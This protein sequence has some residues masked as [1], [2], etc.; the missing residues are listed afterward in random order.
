MCGYASGYA[1]LELSSLSVSR[2]GEGEGGASDLDSLWA[3]ARSLP[4]DLPPD[5]AE[6]ARTACLC[7][8]SRQFEVGLEALLAGL[9]PDCNTR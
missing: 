9:D 6:V 8:A 2:A 1:M 5:L 7:D 4:P 3:L